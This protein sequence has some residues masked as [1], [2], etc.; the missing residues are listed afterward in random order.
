MPD[1]QEDEKA[2][3]S[4]VKEHW[5]RRVVSNEY[6]A[7][8]AILVSLIGAMAV[9]T[10]GAFLTATNLTSLLLRSSIIGIV[11]IGQTF[12]MLSAGI[13][14]SVG[15]IAILTSCLGASLMTESSRYVGHLPVALGILI[16][17]LVAAAMGAA[18]GAMVSRLRMSPLIVT[19]AM[20]QIGIGIAFEATKEGETIQQMPE[21]LAFFGKG[22]IGGIP[23]PIIILVLAVIVGYLVLR[24][25]GFG[26]SIY[27]VG[28][29][30]VSAWLSGIKT[31]NI[32][33]WVYVIS[34]F[35]AGIAGLINLSRIMAADIMGLYGLEI[36]SIVV[37]VVGGVSLFGGKGSIISVVLAVLIL[38]AVGNGMNLLGLNIYMQWVVK[39]M[40]IL[41]AVGIDTLSRRRS[42][43]NIGFG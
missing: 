16:M 34:G 37:V 24:H 39:G 17:L 41:I 3:S 32:R 35:C 28:S 9:M 20:W 10:H 36:D 40:I 5:L 12:V 18:N 22:Q 7:L 8:T 2:F 27:A 38:G 19:L 14:L 31:Q 25:T 23:T 1:N 30:E 21:S 29:S 26:R 11:A 6:F 43:V 33:F 4:P 13:D 15:G 42:K